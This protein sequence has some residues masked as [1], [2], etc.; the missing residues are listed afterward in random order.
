MPMVKTKALVAFTE[1]VQGYGQVHGNPDG[2]SDD[3]RFPKFPEHVA[4]RLAAEKRVELVQSAKGKAK[5]EPEAAL[6]A[7]SAP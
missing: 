1:F 6:P 2:S 3:A 5:G 7:E 4:E